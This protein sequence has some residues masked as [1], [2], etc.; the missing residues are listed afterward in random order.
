MIRSGA[1]YP[2]DALSKGCNIQEFSVGDTP[3]RDEI[4]L[5]HKMLIFKAIIDFSSSS[6]PSQLPPPPA[7]ENRFHD[8]ID[9]SQGIDSVESMPG[10]LKV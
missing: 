4:T 1:Q 8:G 7:D 3:V 6:I 10:S 9:F 5:H 2:R